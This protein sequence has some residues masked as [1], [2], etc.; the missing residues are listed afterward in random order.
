M[1]AQRVPTSNQITETTFEPGLGKVPCAG[2]CKCGGFHSVT[3]STVTGRLECDCPDYQFRLR[4]Q[5]GRCKH[6]KAVLLKIADTI[7]EFVGNYRDDAACNDVLAQAMNEP[8]LLSDKYLYADY[9]TDNPCATACDY[10]RSPHKTV[11]A[12]K[13]TPQA[14]GRRLTRTESEAWY[15]ALNQIWDSERKEDEMPAQSFKTKREAL[16]IPAAGRPKPVYPITHKV[17]L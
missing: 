16:Q 9:S 10:G 1:S 2:S 15:F 8:E 14:Q 4:K 11:F 12:V 13:R 5:N 3:R 6:I 7:L 17:E